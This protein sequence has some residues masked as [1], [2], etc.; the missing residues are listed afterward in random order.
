MIKNP[1]TLTI[2]KT[3]QDM[4]QTYSQGE[5]G[6]IEIGG[7]FQVRELKDTEVTFPKKKKRHGSPVAF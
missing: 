1:D 2:K 6:N 7:K 4:Q 5:V 3:Q